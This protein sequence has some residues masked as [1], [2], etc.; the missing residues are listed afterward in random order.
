MRTL[1]SLAGAAIAAVAL[2]GATA[3]DATVLIQVVPYD[4]ADL[5]IIR[6]DQGDIK[7]I[8]GVFTIPTF[9]FQAPADNLV[10]ATQAVFTTPIPPPPALFEEDQVLAAVTL[11][12]S[13]LPGGS[14]PID[15]AASSIGVGYSG[16]PDGSIAITFL[17]F[18]TAI[19]V[20]PEP[21]PIYS[22]TGSYAFTLSFFLPP[23]TPE[24]STWALM[25]TG[26]GL[27]GAS[28]RS[29]RPRGN[30][31]RRRTEPA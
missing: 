16:L 14:L 24:P 5:T 21:G 3:A 12:G 19:G 28:V 2:M 4:N 10:L 22:L 15:P 29:R 1:A 13:A 6:S 23:P 26:F 25:L 30:P 11:H 8:S 27:L 20:L 31:P 7:S 9:T 17:D 18:D